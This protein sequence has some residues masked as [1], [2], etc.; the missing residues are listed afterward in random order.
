MADAV[1]AQIVSAAGG[2]R[3][4]SDQAGSDLHFVHGYISNLRA[5]VC[6][7]AS[8]PEILRNGLQ[9]YQC[10]TQDAPPGPCLHHQKQLEEA[11]LARQKHAEERNQL[12]VQG[13]SCLDLS[14]FGLDL[15]T[16]CYLIML[17]CS[18]CGL[19]LDPGHPEKP[20]ACSACTCLCTCD[21]FYFMLHHSCA[22]PTF[23]CTPSVETLQRQLAELIEAKVGLEKEKKL[24]LAGGV[25][26][27]QCSTPGAPQGSCSTPPQ[28]SL[29]RTSRWVGCCFWS[30]ASVDRL[31]KAKAECGQSRRQ[32][33][34]LAS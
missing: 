26:D 33:A 21:P 9:Q 4:G 14:L 29:K 28:S 32:T 11:N 6:K 7:G 27:S 24:L 12:I 23:T 2:R 8:M 3:Q 30:C 18:Q 19:Q 34:S 31:L 17:A 1:D 13:W 15:S 20:C 10:N 5:L 16:M 22:M 25:A